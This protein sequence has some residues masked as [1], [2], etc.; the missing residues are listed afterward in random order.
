M[1]IMQINAFAVMC[2]CRLLEPALYYTVVAMSKIL[3]IKILK[4]YSSRIGHLCWNVDNYK[5][6]MD[7]R[8]KTRSRV[9]IFILD[10]TTANSSVLELIK[11]GLPGIYLTGRIAVIL[12]RVIT[13]DRW[14]KLLVPWGDLHPKESRL[15]NTAKWVEIPKIEIDKVVE[16][17]GI[18]DAKSIVFHNRDRAY[19]DSIEG[20]SNFHDYRDFSFKDYLPAIEIL[21]TKGIKA[22]R[23]GRE[24]EES[25]TL[26]N[27]LDLTGKRQNFWEDVVAVEVSRFFVSGNSGIGQLSN[28]LRKPHLFVNQIPF[29]LHH[30]SSFPQNS[31]FMPKKLRDMS[32]GKILSLQDSLSLLGN[33]SI[34]TPDFFSSREIE[35]VNNTEKEISDAVVEMLQRTSMEW[36]D[37]LND[38]K[39]NETLKYLYKDD[40]AEYIF[41]ELGI[42]LSSS[43]VRNNHNWF[44]GL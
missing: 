38:S 18:K 19:L 4:I 12:S 21:Q 14:K 13:T 10:K 44:F 29:D 7:N 25:H 11:N 43:F 42:K 5:N 17:H 6:L 39:I 27:L 36:K 20:D 34:H 30:L 32:S 2:L 35:V 24:I 1:F 26:P 28:L 22:I 9:S 37:Y 31:M 3:E 41:G 16:E 15:A 23:I 40:F 8:K 33:W